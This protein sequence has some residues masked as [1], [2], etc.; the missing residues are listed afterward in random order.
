MALNKKYSH[1]QN[2][3]TR[4]FVSE[5]FHRIYDHLKIVFMYKLAQLITFVFYLFIQVYDL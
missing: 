5:M 1:I 2:Q 3:M 4:T